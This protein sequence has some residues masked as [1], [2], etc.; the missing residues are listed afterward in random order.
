MGSPITYSV[1][2]DDRSDFD[3]DGSTGQLSAAKVLDFTDG[4]S[5]SLV[6]IATDGE[7]RT[8][9]AK[10]VVTT[11]SPVLDSLTVNDDEVEIE[12]NRPLDEGSVPGTDAYTVD[13]S[14]SGVDVTDVDVA[15]DT[16]TVTIGARLWSFDTVRV[17]YTA[18]AN[19]P[20]RCGQPGRTASRPARSPPG[21]PAIARATGS[22]TRGLLE[23]MWSDGTTLWV[24]T[25]TGGTLQN[26]DGLL[27]AI[28]LQ[29]RSRDEPK[30]INLPIDSSHAVGVWSD[31]ATV[32]VASLESRWLRA[33]TRAG[34]QDQGKDIML[35]SEN[36]RPNGIWSDGDVM[37]VSD[38]HSSGWTTRSSPTTWP[39]ATGC[40]GGTSISASTCTPAASG[41]MV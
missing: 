21:G 22:T 40:R 6:V 10:V 17:T 14:G 32:W 29:T 19:R 4:P 28:D 23:S 41:P 33:Y 5:Y 3:I 15:G 34:A 11:P 8:D 18:P 13:V 30:D 7:D 39:T 16:V 31:G 9:R 24:A 37:W 26:S 35:H 27:L 1:G 2:G 36:D 25:R 38:S 12:Y 20:A